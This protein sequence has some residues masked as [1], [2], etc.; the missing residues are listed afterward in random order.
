MSN[1]VVSNIF[2][3]GIV[4]GLLILLLGG[5]NSINFSYIDIIMMIVYALLL[6]IFSF[7]DKSISKKEGIIFLILFVVYYSYVII[8]KEFIMNQ[9]KTGLSLVIIGNICYVL[10]VYFS[11]DNTTNLSD[12]LSGLILGLSVGTNIVGITTIAKYMGRQKKK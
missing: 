1:V 7:N 6:F 5:I 11:K 3:I 9:L 2:N 8:G 12:F 4:I 10:Y